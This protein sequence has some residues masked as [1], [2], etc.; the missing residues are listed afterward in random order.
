MDYVFVAS[1]REAIKASKCEDVAIE[2]TPVTFQDISNLLD[3]WMTI[4]G[5]GPIFVKVR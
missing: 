4:S 3:G 2:G 5:G 1:V